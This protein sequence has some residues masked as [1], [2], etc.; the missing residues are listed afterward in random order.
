MP[1]SRRARGALAAKPFT[2]T[3]KPFTVPDNGNVTLK[4]Q[5]SKKQ[6]ATLR[7]N[8]RIETRLT[9]TLKDAAGRSSVAS[10]TVVLKR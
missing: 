2:L 9:V 5:L 6:L 1:T 3:A 4:M 8:R 7:R 10:A